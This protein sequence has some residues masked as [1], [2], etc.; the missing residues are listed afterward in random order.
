MG[1]CDGDGGQA[2]G[3]EVDCDILDAAKRFEFFAHAGNTVAAGHAGNV[4]VGLDGLAHGVLLGAELDGVVANGVIHQTDDFTISDAQITSLPSSPLMT[5]KTPQNLP[6]SPNSHLNRIFE[7]NIST[8]KYLDDCEECLFDSIFPSLCYVDVTSSPKL[9][10][11][12]IQ[13]FITCHNSLGPLLAGQFGGNFGDKKGDYN[14]VNNSE[15]NRPLIIVGFEPSAA[16]HPVHGVTIKKTICPDYLPTTDC[17]GLRGNFI[18]VPSYSIV[19]QQITRGKKTGNDIGKGKGGK[20]DKNSQIVDKNNSQNNSQN[21]IG[22]HFQVITTAVFKPYE[23]IS[24]LS[25]KLLLPQLVQRSSINSSKDLVQKDKSEKNEESIVKDDKNIVDRIDNGNLLIPNEFD[26][27]KD[28]TT[29]VEQIQFKFDPKILNTQPQLRP[30]KPMVVHLTPNLMKYPPLRCIS[31]NLPERL[32][33]DFTQFDTLNAHKE[34]AYKYIST[35][36]DRVDNGNG[37][38]GGNDDDD[39]YGNFANDFDG[40]CGCLLGGDH[41]SDDV[42]QANTLNTQNNGQ[43]HR[44]N[45]SGRNKGNNIGI[46]PIKAVIP[47]NNSKQIQIQ[48]HKDIIDINGHDALF[49]N[50]FLSLFD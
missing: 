27:N 23:L 6:T 9:K 48:L 43:F 19:I 11:E 21:N 18:I 46:D 33:V 3:V 45:K 5:P 37:N 22:P 25:G 20:I 8:Q 15:N 39:D 28:K 29:Q 24:T 30:N 35:I 7:C 42:H 50:E 41:D 44:C 4:H 13:H 31:L 34:L 10:K 40:V 32:Q 47:N 26:P 16:P 36:M 17:E 2:A 12:H 49:F 1:G 14:T 38:D